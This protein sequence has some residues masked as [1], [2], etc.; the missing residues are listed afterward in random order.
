MQLKQEEIRQAETDLSKHGQGFDYKKHAQ[1]SQLQCQLK[2]KDTE[3]A[4]AAMLQEKRRVEARVAET[5]SLILTIQE[6]VD[7]CGRREHDGRNMIAAKEQELSGLQCQQKA[8]ELKQAQIRTIEQTKGASHQD[9]RAKSM[10]DFQYQMPYANFDK[11]AVFGLIGRL[12]A[13]KS[14]QDNGT[15][16]T[17]LLGGRV[18]NTVVVR[19][20]EVA[21]SL[22][23]GGGL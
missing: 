17:Q 4:A 7:T 5:R 8:I 12:F 15:A 10:C 22:I 11:Q 18:F 19:S 21:V 1:Q 2:I 3:R 23:K 16:I 14:P 6:E 9:H 20:Q 13:V